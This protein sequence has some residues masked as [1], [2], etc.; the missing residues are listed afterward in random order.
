MGAWPDGGVVLASV[1]RDSVTPT[2]M[3]RLYDPVLIAHCFF[4]AYCLF[5]FYCILHFSLLPTA[6][7][8]QLTAFFI[9]FI[10]LSSYFYLMPVF[11]FHV[12]L[13][14]FHVFTCYFFVD[15]RMSFQRRSQKREQMNIH[16]M[17][18]PTV[19]I[20]MIAL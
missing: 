9:L 19:P 18:A 1:R 6:S 16:K 15:V 17:P 3:W 10:P 4:T 11:F 13:T 20:F 8:L 12:P 5:C 7:L 2:L 14:L